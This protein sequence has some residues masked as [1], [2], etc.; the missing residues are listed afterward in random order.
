VPTGY[1]GFEIVEHRREIDA[2]Y[3]PQCLAVKIR[4]D[5]VASWALHAWL[6]S[7]LPRGARESAIQGKTL[8]RPVLSPPPTPDAHAVGRALLAHADALADQLAGTSTQ[9][10]SDEDA[11][12]LIREDPFAFLLAVICDMGI[13]SERAWAL[14]TTCASGSASSPRASWLSAPPG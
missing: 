3:S 1:E 10:T 2:P 13:R 8:S 4:E 6:R 11:D 9:F 14:P 12:R 5:D 7:Q